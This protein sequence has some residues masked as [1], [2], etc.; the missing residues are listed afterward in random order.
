M[1]IFYRSN[2][3]TFLNILNNIPPIVKIFLL[4]SRVRVYVYTSDYRSDVYYEVSVTCQSIYIDTRF[5]RKKMA[6]RA[7]P[8]RLQY[9]KFIVSLLPYT[10][11]N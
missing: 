10:K 8:S 2:I 4:S 1:N 11:S 3:C 7:K 5:A 9:K 6:D